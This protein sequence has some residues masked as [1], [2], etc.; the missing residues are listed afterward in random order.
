MCQKR[1]KFKK[2]GP[3]SILIGISDTEHLH[4][5]PYFLSKMFI[6]LLKTSCH[7]EREQR[8]KQSAKP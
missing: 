7:C 4:R 2:E 1:G 3:L 8:A 5:L 6:F